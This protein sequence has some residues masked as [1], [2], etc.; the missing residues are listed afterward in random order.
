MTELDLAGAHPTLAKL[1]AAALEELAA[2]ATTRS[3]QAGETLFEADTEAVEFFIVRDGLVA[4]EMPTPGHEPLIVETLGPGELVGISWA[5]EPH[6]WNWRALAWTDAEVVA[7]DAAGVRGAA[8]HDP[9]LRIAL[10]EIVAREA[11]GRLHATRVRLMDVYGSV[12]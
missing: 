9:E 12:P 7:F 4:L 1:P 5:F 6:R 8:N 2:N 11:V 3:Y 10:L